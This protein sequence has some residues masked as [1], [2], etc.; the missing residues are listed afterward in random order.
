MD[1]NL[2]PNKV[3]PLG[4][5][6]IDLT[7]ES[8]QMLF[9]VVSKLIPKKDYFQSFDPGY[10][11]INGNVTK[12]GHITICYG[13]KNSNLKKQFDSSNLKIKWQ[14]VSV[15]K[16]IQINLGYQGLYYVIVAI[17]EIDKDI[18]LFYDWVRKNNEL[19]PDSPSF[20]PHLALCYI[21]NQGNYPKELLKKLQ[22]KLVGK[23]VKFDSVNFYYADEKIGS[24]SL[25]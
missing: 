2:D 17:P 5:I 25:L 14:K 1:D 16:E 11:Y 22:Q 8:K 9:E 24:V 10:T 6:G 20:D 7:E 23:T 15:I 21:K 13:V 3:T 18:L 4:G 19:L 12:K